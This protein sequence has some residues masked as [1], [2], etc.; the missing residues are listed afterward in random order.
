[1]RVD[2]ESMAFG[3]ADNLQYLCKCS[4]SQQ[5]IRNDFSRKDG[6]RRGRANPD[7]VENKG[8]TFGSD[9]PQDKKDALLEYLKTL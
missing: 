9:L 2:E 5:F 3:G 7:L 6:V 1:M 4:P 8:H